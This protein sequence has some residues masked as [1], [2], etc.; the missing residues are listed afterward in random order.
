MTWYRAAEGIGYTTDIARADPW[1]VTRKHAAQD[2]VIA[3]A[4]LDMT[5][6]LAQYDREHPRGLRTMTEPVDLA[7]PD[8][9]EDGNIP[10][11]APFATPVGDVSDDGP[12]AEDFARS[13]ARALGLDEDKAAEYLQTT[14]GPDPR[15]GTLTIRDTVTVGGVFGTQPM[16]PRGFVDKALQDASITPQIR[17]LPRVD[18]PD[19]RAYYP[20]IGAWMATGAPARHAVGQ[21]PPG[22]TVAVDIETDGLAADS[23]AIKCLTASWESSEGTQ[24]VLLDPLRRSDDKDSTLAIMHLAGHLVLHNAPFDIPPMYQHGIITLDQIGKVLDTQLYARLAMPNEIRDKY[25]LE[26]LAALVGTPK[27]EVTMTR[28]FNASGMKKE[29]GWRAFDIDRPVYRI[30][31]MADTIVTLRLLPQIQAKAWSQLVEGHPFGSMGVDSAGAVEIMEREQRVNHVMIRRNARGLQVDTD[32]LARYEDEHVKELTAARDMLLNADLDP[33]AG[34]LGFLLVTKLEADGVLPKD[35]PRTG[36][37]RLSATKDDMARLDTL[38]HPLAVAARRT[39]EL[40]KVQGY[41]DKVSGMVKVTGKCHPQTTILG[42]SATG[43]MS[44]SLPELQQFPA[45]ARPIIVC[46]TGLTSVDWAQIEPVIMANCAGDAEYLAGFNAGTEDLYAPIQRAAGVERKVAKVLLLSVMY[47]KGTKS[48]AADLGISVDQAKALN[49]GMFSAMPTTKAFMDK[50]RQIA[51]QHKSIPTADGRILDVPVDKE[52]RQVMA[53]KAVN[54]FCVTPDTLILTDDLRHIRADEIQVGDGVVGFDEYSQDSRGRGT[55]KR[56][57]RHATVTN[58]DVTYKD[59][60]E[61]RTSDG[62]VTTC[63]DDHRWLVRRPGKQPRLAWVEAADLTPDMQLLSLGT[64]YTDYSRD[65]GYLAGLYDGEGC[66][67]NRTTTGRPTNLL[68]SQNKGAVMDG[69]LEAM[70]RLGLT[71]SY[72]PK[73]PGSTS[74]TDTVRVSGLARMMR[75]IGTL[76]PE[77]FMARVR[78]LYDGAELHTT[79]MMEGT[80]H[81]VSVTPV[82]KR[83]VLAIGT[84]TRTLVANGYLSHNCQGSA[85][86]ILSDTIARLDAAGLADSIHLALHDELVV[87][88]EAAQA[89]ADVMRTPPEFLRKWT[90]GADPVFRTDTH[91]MGKTW[92]YV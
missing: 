30:G 64:W 6:A 36:T 70:D 75:T 48:M 88:T 74:T 16:E 50:I 15:Y 35:W 26:H 90:G 60:V 72:V 71:Y 4:S 76:R 37:G 68:F 14:V 13:T 67:T 81:V 89:V 45:D 11:L 55:G 10:H 18:V 73:A 17:Q 20:H 25:S 86:S 1:D 7:Q 56:F 46:D 3:D 53:Y 28:L 87:D 58:A 47:G 5:T 29:E 42:A 40:T 59:S 24:A 19:H 92:L 49:N 69:F 9:D 83:E 22:A 54:Y 27:A 2:L 38:G 32:Y 39:A 34:N 44:Y 31:A 33:D 63:S 41:L 79:R 43:R 78:E 8:G 23:F 51:E 82:G 65:A 80:P 66:L 91:D 57:L 62:K 21:I 52:T 85:Y 12:S 84:S 77:R 61:I